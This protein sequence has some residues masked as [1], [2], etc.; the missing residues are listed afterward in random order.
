MNKDTICEAISNKQI[1][2]FHY[3]IGDD[4]GIRTVEPHMVALNRRDVLCLSAWFLAGHSASKEK[5]G[6]REYSLEGISEIEITD[7]TFSHPREG[8][9]PSGGKIYH[10]V[11]CGL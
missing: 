2:R 8:Y 1:I 5:P 9:N 4:P 7:K 10:N 11:Q 6:F 3:S